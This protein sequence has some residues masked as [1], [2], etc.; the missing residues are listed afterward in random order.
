MNITYNWK[1]TELTKVPSKDGL[2][3]VVTHIKFDYTGTSDE[4]DENSE[5]KSATFHGAVPALPPS[6]EDFKTLNTLTESD[7][8]EWVKDVHPTGHMQSII[9]EK[10]TDSG[11]EVLDSDSLPW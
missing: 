10:L 8:I 6:S 9:I 5:F 4:K 2:S 7:V 3:D 11:E 1:I